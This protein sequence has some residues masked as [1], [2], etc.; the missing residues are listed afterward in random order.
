MATMG[1]TM[2]ATGGTTIARGS[3]ATARGRRQQG[4]RQ[5]DVIHGRG[6]VPHQLYWHEGRVTCFEI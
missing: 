5:Y 1:G 6:D 4:D 2:M 3:T